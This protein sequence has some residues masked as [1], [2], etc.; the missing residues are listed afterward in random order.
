MDGCDGFFGTPE[1]LMQNL[2][3]SSFEPDSALF[4]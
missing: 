1:F 2:C 4:E 3:L